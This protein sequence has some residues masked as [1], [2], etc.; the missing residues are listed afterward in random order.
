MTNLK[1]DIDDLQKFLE[2]YSICPVG[3]PSPPTLMQIA[4]FPDRENVYSNILAFFLDTEEA[5]G[6]GPLFV[7][8]LL[9][10][11]ERRRP[12]GWPT[13][14][15]NAEGTERVEREEPTKQGR[16]D[17]VIECSGFVMCV[18][19][20]IWAKLNNDLG[21]YREHCGKTAGARPVLGVVLS[22]H[23]L[24]TDD[25]A[26]VD[27]QFVN[28]TYPDLVEELKC[29]LGSHIGGHNTKYQYLLF[30]FIE[31]VNQFG[32]RRIMIDHDFLKFWSDNEDKIE[33]IK[34]RCDALQDE[35]RAAETVQK[36]VD[37]CIERLGHSN[38]FNTWNYKKTTAGFDF[39][40]TDIVNGCRPFYQVDFY[41][42]GI[43]HWIY[44]RRGNLNTI[45]D[46]LVEKNFGIEKWE[47]DGGWLGFHNKVSPFEKE[48]LDE[49][50]N[51]SVEIL[52]AL[53]EVMRP[54]E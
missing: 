3:K 17:L 43:S 14:D 25:G 27:H 24:S 22:P 40:V 36:H 37:L 48:A 4:N 53:V 6:F 19:N 39:Q 11:Y 54:V 7:Q 16:I 28:V 42:L 45:W 46:L 5:H 21:E 41:P 8:S 35:I 2:F 26:M 52:T 50:V 12:D 34:A 49:A 13:A 9:A 47:N 29:R 30:D 51:T 33:N 15:S 31:Q 10:A 23:E 18:E 38:P 32:E 20:K 1:P 44:T